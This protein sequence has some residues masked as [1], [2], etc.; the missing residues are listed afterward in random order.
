MVCRGCH[1]QDDADAVEIKH[2]ALDPPDMLGQ[3]RS[4]LA[5]PIDELNDF[6]E[7][8]IS[9]V[10]PFIQVYTIPSTGELAFT[11]HV[12]NFRQRVNHWIHELPIR[13]SN[14][15]FVL[16]RPRVT[17]ANPNQRRRPPF[18]VRMDKIKAA[19]QW[20][21]EHNPYYENIAWNEDNAAAWEEE[22]LPSREEDMLQHV[23]V[24]EKLLNLWLHG[25]YGQ[26]AGSNVPGQAEASAGIADI[27]KDTF[28]SDEKPIW[29]QI[30]DRLGGS[31]RVA[32]KISTAHIYRALV[33]AFDA[34]DNGLLE[35]WTAGVP[36]S[37][38][39]M[40]LDVSDWPEP[41]STLVAELIAAK[42]ASGEE[43]GDGGCQES[44]ATEFLPAEGDEADRMAALSAYTK[45][46]GAK[47]PTFVFGED[48]EPAEAGTG[49]SMPPAASSNIEFA[50]LS[51]AEKRQLPKVDAP[52]IDQKNPISEDEPGYIAKA[53]VR[54]FPFGI[55]DYH[56]QKS[57]LGAGLKFATWA[58][59]ILQY[60]DGR[61]ARHPRFKYFVLNTR[62]RMKTPGLKNVFYRCNEDANKLTRQDLENVETR[63]KL[64]HLA[65]D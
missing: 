51:L 39:V 29:W 65:S 13:P 62:M 47:H 27:V 49:S 10:H 57:R 9:L 24:D 25:V 1:M 5:P 18:P 33:L 46:T 3:T 63:K 23:M 19:F 40:H 6:E 59:Y 55:G 22:D 42:V 35:E 58:K 20:L 7:M 37:M 45:D 64:M 56:D 53:F 12:C 52:M 21:Q 34:T 60:H 11:G 36:D 32:K 50:S 17:K 31:F 43:E 15:P 48:L 4:A 54:I 38:D 44:A 2:F 14:M 30:R 61:A 8:M 26:E 16:V 28:N 41:Y